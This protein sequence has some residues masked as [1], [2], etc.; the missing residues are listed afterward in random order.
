MEPILAESAPHR[1][2]AIGFAVVLAVTAAASLAMASGR[3]HRPRHHDRHPVAHGT[4][5]CGC[6]QL[7][8]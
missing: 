5:V 1:R 4:Y 8:R 7:T 3:H 6:V 2:R